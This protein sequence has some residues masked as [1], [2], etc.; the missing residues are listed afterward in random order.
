MSEKEVAPNRS[1]LISRRQALKGS[2]IAAVTSLVA[3]T[4]GLETANAVSRER[5]EFHGVHQPGVTTRVQ[6]HLAF[7]VFDVSTLSTEAFRSLLIEW[8]A[9]GERLMQ[10]RELAG[11]LDPVFPPADTGETA[12]LSA[13]GLTLTLGFGPSLFDRRFGLRT[14]RPIALVKLPDFPGDRLEPRLSGGD[15]CVQAC[16]DDATVALHAIRNLARLG[17]GT[18]TLR[19]LQLGSGQT[20]TPHVGAKTP[21]NLLG[22]KDGT[23]NL[24]ANDQNQMN[25]HVWVGPDADQPWMVG[26]TYMVARRIRVHLEQWASLPLEDQELTIGRFRHS[27]APLTGRREHDPLNFAKLDIFGAPV[28]AADAHVRVA[29][30][31]ANDGAVVLRRGYNFADGVDQRTGEIDAGLMF[32][33]FQRDPRRQFITLQATLA[34]EDALSKYTT[35]TGSAI[36]ACPPGAARGTYV[37]HHLFG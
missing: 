7:G 16:A 11:S 6:S 33:C 12:E 21:R 15:L 27:G 3:A 19:S 31:S 22:F 29:S 18:V 1:P 14:K 35:H 8:S 23:N 4:S 10:G 20:S 28:I 9:A 25:S 26:G 24:R 17:V 5:F 30:R 36:F 34:S 2:S 13:A 32:I 37:G